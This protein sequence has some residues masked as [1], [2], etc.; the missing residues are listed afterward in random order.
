MRD[1]SPRPP[2]PVAGP[3]R[4]GALLANLLA[5]L[6]F[7]LLAM[8]ICLPSMQEW[9]AIFGVDQPAVQLTFSAY[10]LTYGSLQLFYG[11]L[12]D[13]LGRRRILL[14]GLALSLAGAAAAALASG[15]AVLVAARALQGAGAAAG[16][17]VGRA[18]V[19]DLF[20]GPER[21]RVMAY[22]GM[23]LGLCP[24]LA[25]LIGGQLHVR[26]GWQANFGLMALL[27]ALLW[28]LSWRMLPRPVQPPASPA[29]AHWLRTMGQAYLRLAREPR[30]LA[31]VSILAMTTAT[32]YAFLGG[33]PVVLRSLGVGPQGIGL[34]I[35]CVPA[36]YIA[37][38]FLTSRIAHRVGERRML[39]GGQ[40][41]TLAGIVLMLALGLGGW[42][43]P[44]AFAL[45][46]LLLGLGHGLLV[47]PALA[48]TVGLL[49]ALAGS[50]A[51]VAGV[52]QQLMGALGGYLVGLMPH[53]GVVNLGWLMLALAASGTLPMLRLKPAA[54]VKPAGH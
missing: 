32:F 36:S 38:S 3:P 35:L 20:T 11:P 9:G 47:P 29:A 49:P 34:Y 45:P 44:L 27:A 16:M 39:L 40:A 19:Q 46:L 14:F 1:F 26:W 17:V 23:T 48:G 8:T 50:A 30:F 42:H 22:I 2:R 18:M 6:A 25:T 5:Q 43:S 10:V 33:A 52:A 28:A 24:P 53:H 7:G 37:G 54:P 15:L 21:T 12:S 51:A 41:L 13:R 31:Y 4:R